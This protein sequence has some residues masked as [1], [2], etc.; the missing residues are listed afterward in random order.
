VIKIVN[1]VHAELLSIGEVLIDFIATQENLERFQR[2]FGGS[3][4]NLAINLTKMG[5]KTVFAGC[6]G[7]DFLGKYVYDTFKNFNVDTTLLSELKSKSTSLIVI[8]EFQDPPKPIFYK[9]ADI[10]YEFNELLE[11]TIEKVK[12][13][14]TTAHALSFEPLRTT[15]ITAVKIAAENNK[16]VT[17]DPNYRKQI[18]PFDPSYLAVVLDLLK[19]VDYIK[20][21]LDDAQEIFQINSLNPEEI[22]KLF[23]N[24]GIKQSVILTCGNKGVYYIDES[25]NIKFE[26]AVKIP[27][28]EVIGLTGAGDAFFAGFISSLLKEKPLNASIQNGIRIASGKIKYKG[29]II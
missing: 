7:K 24:N 20:P 26:P 11:A 4:A 23:K 19:Y 1:P 3:P 14:H 27:T 2:F 9:N 5:H 25:K 29:T 21:S 16:I 15:V 17:F 28:K 12:I 22:I 13:V 10:E 8:N 6:T 18:N